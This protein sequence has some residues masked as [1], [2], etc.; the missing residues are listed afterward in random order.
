MFFKHVN[1]NR[2][3]RFKWPQF[4]SQIVQNN[5]AT[6]NSPFRSLFQPLTHPSG[7]KYQHVL[8]TTISLNLIMTQQLRSQ[9]EGAP[10]DAWM[11]VERL[12]FIEHLHLTAPIDMFNSHHGSSMSVKQ[13]KLSL[14]TSWC[15]GHRG[16]CQFFE[17]LCV[18][19]LNSNCIEHLLVMFVFDF[20][21]H[22]FV[23]LSWL[24]RTPLVVGNLGTFVARSIWNTARGMSFNRLYRWWYVHVCDTVLTAQVN[25]NWFINMNLHQS[26]SQFLNPKWPKRISSARAS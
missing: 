11:L 23:C 26:I 14:P 20:P 15:F 10:V 22:R 18:F 17:S 3:L 6:L 24:H 8:C 25:S 16:Q 9:K 1:V 4:R 21:L 13:E 19:K 12:V 2:C 5:F 7:W